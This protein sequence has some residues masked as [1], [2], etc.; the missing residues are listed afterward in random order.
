ME[1]IYANN[2]K[3]YFDYEILETFEAGIV[4]QGQEVKATRNNRMNLNGSYATFHNGEL[5]LLNSSIAKYQPKNQSSDYAEDR[6]RKLLL[7]KKQLEKIFVATKEKRMT[8]VPLKAYP[9]NGKIKI[10]L[11]LGRGKKSYDK[12]ETIKQRDFK[13]QVKEWR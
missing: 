12:R 7:S 2:K 8:L 6:S 11:G 1:K 4:L 5:F 13:K 10:L 3:A 9:Q